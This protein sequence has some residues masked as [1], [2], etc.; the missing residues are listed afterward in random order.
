[1]ERWREVWRDGFLPSL[2]PAAVDA[3]RDALRDDDPRLIQG[4]TTTP[5]PLACVED[6][7]CEAGCALGYC[8]VIANGGFG[9][10]TVGQAE[11]FFAR[12]CFEADQ[13]L[14]EPA[15]CRHFLNWF[16]DTP[17]DELRRELLAE[18]PAGQ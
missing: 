12:M 15:A 6:W 7:P 5:P 10:A 14:G 8:G 4:G 16:D 9:E 1:M 17:R 2:P 18:L 3:L 13:R 11:E